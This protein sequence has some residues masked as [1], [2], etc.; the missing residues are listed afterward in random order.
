MQNKTNILHITVDNMNVYKNG[1][2]ITRAER[3]NKKQIR[4]ALLIGLGLIVI[5]IVFNININL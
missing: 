5:A 3:Q 1:Q 2:F 4:L